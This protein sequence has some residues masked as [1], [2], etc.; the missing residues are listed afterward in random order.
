MSIFVP[1]Y[2]VFVSVVDD[3]WSVKRPRV[4]RNIVYISRHCQRCS[5]R[6]CRCHRENV[7]HVSLTQ[8]MA[9]LTFNYRNTVSSPFCI[10][11]L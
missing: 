2:E 1:N 6:T 8:L 3:S 7:Q 5:R 4:Y 9:E 11:P 10:Q